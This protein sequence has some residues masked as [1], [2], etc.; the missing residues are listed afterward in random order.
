MDNR[1]TESQCKPILTARILFE[2]ADE[3]KDSNVLVV[4]RALSDVRVKCTFKKEDKKNVISKTIPNAYGKR[5]TYQMT[6]IQY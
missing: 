2:G 3:R 4:K 1:I 6:H 5:P